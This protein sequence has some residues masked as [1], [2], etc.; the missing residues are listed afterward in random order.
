MYRLSFVINSNINAC[1]Y[2]IVVR[3]ITL[4]KSKNRFESLSLYSVGIRWNFIKISVVCSNIN[5][6]LV[7]RIIVVAVLMKQ[8][9]IFFVFLRRF[10]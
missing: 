6:V 5:I 8:R 7:I 3:I 9:F 1:V 2:L 4:F 10:K